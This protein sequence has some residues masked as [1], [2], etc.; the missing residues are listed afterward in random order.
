MALSLHSWDICGWSS[1]AQ[2]D[3]SCHNAARKGEW[4]KY[5]GSYH[6]LFLSFWCKMR[7]DRPALFSLLGLESCNSPIPAFPDASQ[8]VGGPRKGQYSH[9]RLAYLSLRASS[10]KFSLVG[11][12]KEV[13]RSYLEAGFLMALRHCTYALITAGLRIVSLIHSSLPWTFI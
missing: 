1:C 9:S 6:Q 11:I 4:E 2:V 13:T 3:H 7:G 10:G 8:L 12:R 5:P